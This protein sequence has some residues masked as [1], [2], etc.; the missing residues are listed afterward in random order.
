MRQFLQLDAPRTCP[1]A[2]PSSS[3][4]TLNNPSHAATAPASTTST[5]TSNSNS[6]SKQNRLDAA[7]SKPKPSID[8]FADLDL[9]EEELA[10]LA[11]ELTS[12]SPEETYSSLLSASQSRRRPADEG[13]SSMMTSTSNHNPSGGYRFSH[14]QQFTPSYPSTSP[15]KL[16]KV[17]FVQPIRRPLASEVETDFLEGIDQ[18]NLDEDA[19]ERLAREL[20]LEEEEHHRRRSTVPPAPERGSSRGDAGESSA[21][22]TTTE[23]KTVESSIAPPLGDVTAVEGD[24][25]ASLSKL[26]KQVEALTIPTAGVVV[27]E[28]GDRGSGASSQPKKELEPRQIQVEPVSEFETRA[29]AE[30][31]RAAAAPSPPPLG[32]ATST[33]PV[34]SRRGTESNTTTTTP[35][36]EARQ[37][38]TDAP[39]KSGESQMPNFGVEAMMSPNSQQWQQRDMGR[40]HEGDGNDA[41]DT[42]VAGAI[43]DGEL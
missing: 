9:T 18:D 5:S 23:M 19:L 21:S 31:E 6:N 7:L 1:P 13:T 43:R 38:K 11:R 37:L 27:D 26:L 32:T 16:E 34:S 24:G 29:R 40:N 10:S 15:L 25:G 2:A 30:A 12:T 4:A 41:L 33:E 3:E 22:T 14:T 36:Q 28:S 35:P 39:T 17:N 20:E 8:D 42:R